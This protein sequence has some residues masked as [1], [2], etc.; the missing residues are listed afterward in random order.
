MISVI[1]TCKNRL[2]YLKD[3]IESYV[4]CPRVRE[5][6]V[7]DF[8]STPPLVD[9]MMPDESEKLNLIRV[10]NQPIWKIG[11]AQN[12]G[13]SFVKSD[14]F[15][16]IDCD[17]AIKYIDFYVDDLIKSN[18]VFYRGKHG[19]GVSSGLLLIKKRDFDRVG[20][21]NE[22]IS[23]WGGDDTDLYERL[24]ESGLTAKYFN[25]ADFQEMVQPMVDKNSNA[26]I[27]D[28]YLFDRCSDLASQPGFSLIRNYVLCLMRPQ[29]S[30]NRLNFFYDDSSPIRVSIDDFDRRR[31]LESRYVDLANGLAMYLFEDGVE[32]VDLLP[33]GKARKKVIE[34]GRR[35][36][37]SS[38]EEKFSLESRVKIDRHAFVIPF[39][40]NAGCVYRVVYEF[41]AE[42]FGNLDKVAVF[43]LSD[44][45]EQ[46]FTPPR[47]FA[48]S[49]H[50]GIGLYRY[51]AYVYDGGRQSF[52]FCLPDGFSEAVAK[53]LPWG[54][55]PSGLELRYMEIKRI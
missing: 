22:W 29:N 25:A 51:M 18:G 20:G 38:N 19:D 14:I 27:L 42:A 21:Y 13:A 4:A 10:N 47:G 48:I 45:I 32:I 1:T 16:K 40:F 55:V 23:G 12:I 28:G 7:V 33:G 46:Y 50:K 31:D 26:K 34:I 37:S 24:I 30:L 3:T 41:E 49:C 53:V 6:V 11:L 52:T 35:L 2:Y 17:V 43:S 39:V 15:L 8:D 54:I 44:G 36:R 9:E 5:V